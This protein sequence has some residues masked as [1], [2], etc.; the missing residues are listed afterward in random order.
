MDTYIIYYFVSSY[1]INL[2]VLPLHCLVMFCMDKEYDL[3]TCPELL[4]T[5]WLFSPLCL[6]LEI[7]IPVIKVVFTVL[8]NIFKTMSGLLINFLGE[9]KYKTPVG[10]RCLS[11]NDYHDI[12][13]GNNKINN[14][15]DNIYVKHG[16]KWVSYNDYMGGP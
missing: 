13:F 10:W 3:H 4:L 7:L 5:C 9:S 14:V 1:L 15:D 11:R 16:N 8:D 6:I 2:A 12:M